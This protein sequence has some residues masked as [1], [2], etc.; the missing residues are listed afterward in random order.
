MALSVSTLAQYPRFSLGLDLGIERNFR[1][2]QRYFTLHN[3]MHGDFHIMK[4]E[5]LR[6]S[7][8]YGSKG[9]FRNGL[10]AV[11]AGSSTNPQQLTY[12]N[13]A[14]MRLRQL[15][16]AWKHYFK[17]EP[18]LEEGWNLYGTA[19]FGLLMGE[20]TNVYSRAIDTTQYL[21]PVKEGNA[22]FKRLGLDLSLGWEKHLSA[23]FY[24]FSEARLL[25]PSPGYPSEYLLVND[26]APFAAVFCGGL[27]ILF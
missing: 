24:F 11:A 22:R 27:R 7:F 25:V 2:D 16:V 23:D 13:N 6:F 12:T 5:G 20:V 21:V 4:K 15:T 10:T 3:T 19:G 14:T 9:K 18:S 1:K 26:N 8:G 17:G